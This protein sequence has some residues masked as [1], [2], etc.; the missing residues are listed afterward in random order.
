MG[1]EIWIELLI[2]MQNEEFT[3]ANSLLGSLNS[4]T[5]LEYFTL[6]LVKLAISDYK[7]SESLLLRVSDAFCHQHSIKTLLSLIAVVNPDYGEILRMFRSLNI[8]IT[9]P[10][11]I[12]NCLELENTSGALILCKN[13]SRISCEHA[14]AAKA[15][16]YI[17]RQKYDKSIHFLES[18]NDLPDYKLDIMFLKSYCFVKKNHNKCAIIYLNEM[19]SA[20]NTIENYW[21]LL[22]IAYANCQIFQESYWCFMKCTII[23]SQ[24]PDNWHNLSILYYKTN[25]I[26]ESDIL[27]RKAL[28]LR[29]SLER[30][31]EFVYPVYDISTFGKPKSH[32][33]SLNVPEAYKKLQICKPRIVR[34]VSKSKEDHNSE[35]TAAELLIMNDECEAAAA[36]AEIS[37]PHK[38]RRHKTFR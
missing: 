35:L 15:L 6:G 14:P 38:R 8:E 19:I 22:G 20:N 32:S 36:L 7:S 29:P 1:E 11:H 2:K 13:L 28:S 17:L 24:R 27:F 33:S 26:A 25:Q 10:S 31:L 12:L 34:Q 5:D 21:A 37:L 4:R 23:N 30:K 3:E 9:L 18:I 16:G